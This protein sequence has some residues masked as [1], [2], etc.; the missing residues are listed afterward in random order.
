[1]SIDWPI[2]N[3]R[4]SGSFSTTMAPDRSNEMSFS[5]EV[6]VRYYGSMVGEV[7]WCGGG[8]VGRPGGAV[9]AKKV[10]VVR[11]R[12]CLSVCLCFGTGGVR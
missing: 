3:G 7:G 1:M 2:S 9:R 10:T 12:V 5:G 4:R 6:T 11:A 8:C